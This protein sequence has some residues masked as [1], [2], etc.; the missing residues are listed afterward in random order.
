MAEVYHF[1]QPNVAA[2]TKI[3]IIPPAGEEKLSGFQAVAWQAELNGIITQKNHVETVI[4]IPNSKYDKTKDDI[5]TVQFQNWWNPNTGGIKAWDGTKYGYDVNKVR[6]SLGA[7][8]SIPQNTGG[9]FGYSTLY[10]RGIEIN[11]KTRY[12]LQFSLFD[13]RGVDKNGE[14]WAI[15]KDSSGKILTG[16]LTFS[17]Q[18]GHSNYFT[19]LPT[20]ASFKST[21]FSTLTFF[22]VS[23]SRQQLWNIMTELKRRFKVNISPEPNLHK[24]FACGMT[25]EL[26]NADPGGKIKFVGENMFLR[27]EY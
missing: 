13:D 2:P 23:V 8:I 16:E 1:T 5:A 15:D 14:S 3:Q 24:I 9:A 6:L 12:W 20:S 21:P 10:L 26:G 25:P 27:T 19:L 7:M 17:G 22:G 18:L 4:T 11:S